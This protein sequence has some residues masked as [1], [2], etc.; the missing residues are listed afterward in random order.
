MQWLFV[1]KCLLTNNCVDGQVKKVNGL[2]IDN[3]KHLCGL[4]E[5]C[6]SESLRFDLDDDRVIALNYQ[7]AKV[8][9]SGILKRH[10]ITVRMA[11]SFLFHRQC[12]RRTQ[13][14]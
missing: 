9:I 7:S 11:T 8:A 4:V 3:L 6:G 2:E 14:D 13:A 1:S 10:R 5:D 12:A